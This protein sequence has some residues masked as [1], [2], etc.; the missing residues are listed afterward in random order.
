MRE[1]TM[2]TA[3]KHSKHKRNDGYSGQGP[4]K[5]AGSCE[6]LQC[7]DQIYK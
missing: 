6:K 4:K 7:K 5:C 2:W 3:Q 1:I